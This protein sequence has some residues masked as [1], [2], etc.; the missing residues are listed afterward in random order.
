MPT[1]ALDR[2]VRRAI[3]ERSLVEAVSGFYRER[4]KQ[5]VLTDLGAQ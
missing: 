4:G 3:L 1:A 5:Q 2:E